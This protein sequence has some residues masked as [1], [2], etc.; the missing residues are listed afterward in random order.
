MQVF[1]A[2]DVAWRTRVAPFVQGALDEAEI[3]GQDIVVSRFMRTNAWIDPE[4]V[5]T[6]LQQTLTSDGGASGEPTGPGLH[7]T[8]LDSTVYGDITLQ[9]GVANTLTYVEGQPFVVTFTNQGE[10]DEFDIRVTVRIIPDD[11]GEPITMADTVDRLVQGESAVVELVP[12][13]APP[14]GT[15]VTIQTR[16]APVPGEEMTDNNRSEYPAQFTE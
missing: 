9:P 2:S 16:V 3:G 7:G 15:A 13:P 14:V 11:G 8:G 4:T 6:A 10:N 12:D 5:A 1:L